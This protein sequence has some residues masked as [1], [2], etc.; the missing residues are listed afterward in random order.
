MKKIIIYSILLCSAYLQAKIADHFPVIGNEK[1]IVRDA[2]SGRD[3]IF[4][5]NS[6]YINYAQYPHNKGWLEDDK[7]VLFT[8]YRPSPEGIVRPGERQMLA[9]NIETGD[10]YRLATLD[11]EDTAKYGKYHLTISGAYQHDYA[12]KANI[13]IYNDITGHNLYLL[14]LNTGERKQIWHVDNG[15]INDLPSITDDGTR[16]LIYVLHPAPEVAAMPNVGVMSAV[17]SFDI[18]PETTEAAAP[19]LLTTFI[20][21]KIDNGAN[22]DR[23]GMYLSHQLIN[24]VNKEEF[25]FCHGYNGFS[26]G[27]VEFA[28]V[29]YGKTDGSE[30]RMACPTPQGHIFTHELWGPKGRLIYFVDIVTNGGISAVD[31]RTGKV[32]KIIEDVNPRCLHISVS[33]DERRI[34]FDTQRFATVSPLDEFQ[35]H[36]EDI[37]LLDVATG[38]TTVLAHQMEGLN[39]PRQ[40]HPIINRGG[41]KVCFTV[42]EA[43]KCKVA[44]VKID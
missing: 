30:I 5:T 23:N 8:S 35:N 20:H 36:L 43:A 6:D 40:M 4:L 11:F 15:T 38:Q 31:P 25:S 28:R 2:V 32:R 29:W 27:S 21:R 17:Y 10:I 37:V 3:I 7:Y 39:H 14:N 26:D 9:A 16:A 41:D 33:G 18:N 44:V 24:P 42:A 34:V 12:P 19:K 22:N 13:I 1:H